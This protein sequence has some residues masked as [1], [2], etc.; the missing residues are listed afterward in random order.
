MAVPSLSLNESIITQKNI[1]F[2]PKKPSRVKDILPISA[3]GIDI[4]ADPC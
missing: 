2:N 1:H 4:P 3:T